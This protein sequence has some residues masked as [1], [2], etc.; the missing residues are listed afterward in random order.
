MYVPET[1]HLLND[2]IC[3]LLG[4]LFNWTLIWL[5]VNR[6]PTDMRIYRPILLQSCV[7]DLIYL[8]VQLIVQPVIYSINGL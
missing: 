3:F 2:I 5:I 4:Y 6:T 7:I 1:F 8:A